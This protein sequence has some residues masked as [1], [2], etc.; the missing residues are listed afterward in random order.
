MVEIMNDIL[1]IIVHF[2]SATDN[3]PTPADYFARLSKLFNFALDPCSSKENAKCRRHFT[4]EDN[5]LAQSWQT[6]GAVFMNPP[7]GREIGKWVKKAYEESRKGTPVVCLLP[8][9]TDTAWWNDYCTKGLIKF[10][11]GRLKFG[12]ADAGA[13]FPSAIVIFANLDSSAPESE[14]QDELQLVSA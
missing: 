1:P 9:R 12:N 2:S 13:P 14:I 3:W 8:A 6:D 11:R 7:Y 4:T 5:G 10:V